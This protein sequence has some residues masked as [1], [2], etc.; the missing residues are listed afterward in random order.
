VPYT[1]AQTKIAVGTQGRQVI[2]YDSAIPAPVI[3]PLNSCTPCAAISSP[4]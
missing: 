3:N 2:G 1:N 4:L